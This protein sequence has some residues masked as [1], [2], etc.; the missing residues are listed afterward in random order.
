MY[1]SSECGLIDDR[2]GGGAL[3]LAA[4][5]AAT[6][7]TTALAVEDPTR[8]GGG[9]QPSRS[10]STPVTPPHVPPYAQRGEEDGPHPHRIGVRLTW[11]RHLREPTLSLGQYR[12][13]QRP[14]AV[15][16][17]ATTAGVNMSVGSSDRYTGGNGGAGAA[18]L[19]HFVTPVVL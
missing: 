4:V 18:A 12:L 6:T 13:P 11:W 14:T 7:T 15:T 19:K 8:G 2:G 16:I 1:C 17:V 10:V 5:S 3:R 9:H